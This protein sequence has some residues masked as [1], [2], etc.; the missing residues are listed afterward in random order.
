MPVASSRAVVSS[1]AVVL[2]VACSS[3]SGDDGSHVIEPPPPGPVVD[4]PKKP[5]EAPRF[6]AFAPKPPIIMSSGGKVLTSPKVVLFVYPDDPVAAAAEAF[7]GKIG[8]SAYWSTVTKEYGVGPA[9]ASPPIVVTDPAPAA[10]DDAEIRTWLASQVDGTHPDVP[11]PDGQTV[12]VVLYP[13]GTAVTREK[14]PS[15]TGFFGYHDEALPGGGVSVPYI[16]VPRC[17]SKGYTD[18]EAIGVALSHE[19]VEAATDPFT[20][21]APAYDNAGAEYT[22]WRVTYQDDEAADFCAPYITTSAELGPVARIWSNAAAKAG[23]HPCIP[24]P[25]EPYFVAVPVVK[26]T[27]T[28]DGVSYPGVTVPYGLKVTID[29]QLSSEAPTDDFTVEAHDVASYVYGLPAQLSLALD[30]PTGKNGDVLRL[31]IGALARGNTNGAENVSTFIV[32]A[33]SKTAINYW[34]AFVSNQ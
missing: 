7:L 11:L 24:A 29:V 14:R 6:P 31:T 16:V 23:H 2:L 21:T 4:P 9:T 5:V 17:S 3:S 8:K 19:L 13:K 26:D 28:Y 1:F 20:R 27:F 33:K 12:Y 34:S 15:C 22:A 18:E 25:A 32:V 30:R 10:I